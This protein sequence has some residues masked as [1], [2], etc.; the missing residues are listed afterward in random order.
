MAA[1][2]PTLETLRTVHLFASMSD[3]I[4]EELRAVA[5]VT[6]NYAGHILFLEGDP[7]AGLHI[8]LHGRVKISRFARSGREQVVTVIQA[9]HYFNMVPV[10]DDRPCPANAQLLDDSRLLFLQTDDLRA[11]MARHPA[12]SLALLH[13][14]ASFTRM[15]APLTQAEIAAQLGTVRE[16]VGRSLRAFEALGLI[17]ID[18]GAV[19]ILDSAGLYAQI[20]E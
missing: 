15:P 3:D 19:H 18:R 5:V 7:A 6:D 8:V 9:G 4:L 2:S 13:D 17:R 12:L 20:E 16:M 11:V 10:F 14:I 1:H